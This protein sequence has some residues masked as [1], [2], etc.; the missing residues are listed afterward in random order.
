MPAGFPQALAHQSFAFFFVLLKHGVDDVEMDV[1]RSLFDAGRPCKINTFS[2][3]IKSLD[4]MITFPP[5]FA[6]PRH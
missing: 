3:I 4:D 2:T 6:K 1:G 5:M